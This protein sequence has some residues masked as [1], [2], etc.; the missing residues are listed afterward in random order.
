MALRTKFALVLVLLAGVLVVNVGA[1]VW[2]L[3]FLRRELSWP[4]ESIQSV[5]TGLH[6]IKR[7]GERQA[8]ILGSGRLTDPTV[9]PNRADFAALQA[10]ISNELDRLERLPTANVRSGISNARNLRDRSDEIGRLGEAWFD[11]GATSNTASLVELIDIRHEL[12]ERIEGRIL[13][14]AELAV[15]HGHRLRTLVMLILVISI[16]G[17]VAIAVL[18]SM[19]VRRWVLVP[20]ETLRA[21]AE[22]L[23]RGEFEHRISIGTRDELGRLGDEFNE[24]AGLIKQMQDE[25]VE[26]ERLAAMGEMARRI[27]HNLRT[28]LAGIRNLAEITKSE[29]DADSDLIEVQDRIMSSVDRFEGWLTEMLR[30]SSPLQLDPRPFC[31]ADLVRSVIDAHADAA[32]GRGL[33]IHGSLDALPVRVVGDSSHLE[34]AL[35]A[36]VS[37]ALEYAPKGSEVVVE[38]GVGDGYWSVRV[39]DSGPGIP[40]DLQVSIFRPYFTTR[41][42]GTG[43]GL[44]LVKRVA[45]QHG[46][47]IV[48]RSPVDPQRGVGTAF[49]LRLP[50]G[51]GDG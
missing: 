14:D 51:V 33:S 26:R 46:G 1:S 2:G 48:V 6:E 47:S 7:A 40:A 35:T 23:G 16:I 44:A 20:V 43:I 28:P 31:P 24:M 50:L 21:G 15:D 3:L 39:I 37:N 38:G 29:L 8:A 25:R 4:L 27:V 42:G 36:L 10:K 5:M 17:A 45:D 11:E 12:I 13:A 30:A 49:E 34:H 18:I 32:R 22:R 19:L 41:S 9:A